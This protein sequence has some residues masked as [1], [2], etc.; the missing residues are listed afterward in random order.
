MKL[1][2]VLTAILI[3]LPYLFAS[4]AYPTIPIPSNPPSAIT[5][6]HDRLLHAV[7]EDSVGI[8]L[9]SFSTD[10]PLIQA[11][12]L[13]SATLILVGILSKIRYS[14]QPLDRRKS[15]LG[16][17]ERLG[18][19]QERFWGFASLR[20][21]GGRIL[22]ILLP[23][24]A[25]M[26]LGGSRTAI[27]LLTVVATGIGSFDIRPMKHT[28]LDNWKRIIRTR[29]T[30]CI[31]L[32]L[33]L[34]CDFLNFSANM[35][36]LILGHLALATSVLA[37]PPPLPTADWSLLTISR[38]AS[39]LK[40]ATSEISWDA[41]ASTRLSLPKPSSPLISSPEDTKLTLLAGLTLSLFTIASAI[42]LSTSPLI[43]YD[44]TIFSAL[45]VASATAL[46]FFSLPSSLRTQRKPGV[47]IGCILITG[48]SCLQYPG[49]WKGFPYIGVLCVLCYAAATFDTT[50]SVLKQDAG[51]H[52]HKHHGNHH[53]HGNH[54]RIS[55]YLIRRVTS[56]SIAHSIL[57]EKDS[58]RIAYFAM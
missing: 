42:V 41:P 36:A 18:K 55:G 5:S 49:I 58:R 31:V 14:D 7:T 34:L 53:L 11:C 56:G 25:T 29:R 6:S 24:Y 16:N 19:K 50:T 47:L 43:S 40:S 44:A 38:G 17:S 57:I 48:F 22:S 54:S 37:F 30:T 45:S 3:P 20:Q 33:G 4:L 32:L 8:Q 15:S 12:T 27:V 10:S 13:S 26:Q 51:D 23:F 21:I 1:P 2:E 46:L 39:G 35:R 9:R 28:F 52:D